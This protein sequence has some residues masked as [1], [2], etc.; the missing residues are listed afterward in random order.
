MTSFTDPVDNTF[1]RELI[2]LSDQDNTELLQHVVK[3]IKQ[4]MTLRPT[5]LFADIVDVTSAY[6]FFVQNDI[7][8]SRKQLQPAVNE[9]LSSW[10]SQ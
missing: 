1:K 8:L 5:N 2:A 6:Y 3:N 10:K 7:K 4:P 9:A